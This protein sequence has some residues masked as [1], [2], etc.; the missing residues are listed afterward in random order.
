MLGSGGSLFLCR[1]V[2]LFLDLPQQLFDLLIIFD[3]LGHNP[4]CSHELGLL[5]H[6]VVALDMKQ[7]RERIGHAAGDALTRQVRWSCAAP[8]VTGI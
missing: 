7:Q 4:R 6:W 1:R 5:R 3:P 2:V 8:S